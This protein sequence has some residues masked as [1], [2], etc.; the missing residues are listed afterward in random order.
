MKFSNE[1][2]DEKTGDTIFDVD[3]DE[4]ELQ[5]FTEY[6]KNKGQD[7]ENMKEEEIL[8]FAIVNLIKDE[9]EREE[10]EQE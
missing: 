3:Y 10:N 5:L 4:I 2:I 8:Q 6:A 1:R 9:I 7:V